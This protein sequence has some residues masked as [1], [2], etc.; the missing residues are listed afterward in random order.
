[1]AKDF[2]AQLDNTYHIPS[3]IMILNGMD[4][5]DTRQ[6]CDTVKDFETFKQQTGMELRYPGLLTYEMQT[7]QLRLCK[8]GKDGEF[9]WV[10]IVDGEQV[11]ELDKR[12]V[13][14]ENKVFSYDIQFMD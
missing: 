12:L 9:T 2:T 5:T 4:P 10:Y 3:S 11:E 13:K 14:V 1:M 8:R 6:T 7:Q